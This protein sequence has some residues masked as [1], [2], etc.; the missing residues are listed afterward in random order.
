[1]AI[2]EQTREVVASREA[3]AKKFGDGFDGV[4]GTLDMGFITLEQALHGA[5]AAIDSLRAS[6]DYNFALMIEQLRLQSQVMQGVFRQMEAMHATLQ[7]PNLTQAR[8]YFRI[9]CDRL[10]KGLLDKALE[11]FL[12]S[13]EKDD[14]NFMTQLMIGKLYLYGANDECNIVDLDKAKSHLLSAARYARAETRLLPEARRFESEALLHAAISSYAQAN[15]L[16]ISGNKDQAKTLIQESL[17]LAD[18]ARQADPQFAESHYHHAKIAALIGDGETSVCNNCHEPD[19]PGAEVAR[20][21]HF[22]LTSL[23]AAYDSALTLQA[24]VE[25]KGMDDL[26]IEFILQE[27]RQ[28]LTQAR[29]LVHTFDSVQVNKKIKEGLDKT[30]TAILEAKAQI[31]DYYFR[32]RGFGA[33]TF[34][35]TLLIAALFL[36]IREIDQRTLKK[37][38]P[39]SSR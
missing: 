2:S 11:S 13:A 24:E 6:L 31:E 19:D 14:A 23:S 7:N 22:K 3:L 4:R 12:R 32:R 38:K 37:D 26:D 25:R 5:T 9:G 30:N 21:I 17:D 8:E 28:S 36:K 10:V 1:M 18:Q 15:D 16:G 39:G 34:I 33:A 20:A 29:T 27:A 35:I